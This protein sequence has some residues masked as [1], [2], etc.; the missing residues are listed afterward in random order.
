M[1]AMRAFGSLGCKV[2]SMF[3]GRH[4]DKSVIVL[5]SM[6]SDLQSESAESEGSEGQARY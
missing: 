2:F 1:I 4:F 6:V 3:K 5:C